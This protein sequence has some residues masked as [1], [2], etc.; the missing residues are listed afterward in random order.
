MATRRRSSKVIW[1]RSGWSSGSICW[2]LLVSGRFP[3]SKAIIPD[4][5]E[6]FLTPSA[7]RDTHIFGGLGLN[8][9]RL[10]ANHNLF[11][12]WA[13]DNEQRKLLWA[14]LNSTVTVLSKHQFGRAAGVEGNLKTEVVDANMMLVPDIRTASPHV[15]ARAIAACERI[16][17]R[18]AHRYLYDEF[19]LD[20][21]QALDDATL[22]ILGINDPAER[23]ALRD[24]I[25]CDL[26]AFQKATRE[27][28]IIAQRDRRNSSRSTVS[29]PQNM[30][31]ELWAEHQESLGLLE[32]PK[33]FVVAQNDGEW[34]DLP[35]GP[36]EV[37]T[38]LFDQGGLLKA[39][40]VRIGGRDG[41]VIEVGTMS[42]GQFLEVLS[43]CQRS[44]RI[45]LPDPASC[46]EAVSTFQRYRDDLRKRLSDLAKQRTSDERRQTSVVDALL[47]KALQ[48]RQ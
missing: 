24:H 21:R 41:I 5:Q 29:T 43:L 28:E 12:L 25:Y 47:R 35:S 10:P 45:R 11:E 34:L 48:W 1:M 39:G 7:H 13:L 20:D 37:G 8:P 44:G 40:T 36:V 38:A 4:G 17:K 14:V 31:D 18:D 2:V 42:R 32:F 26:T 27:R 22:E 9:D 6:H 19:V 30:A 3:V 33:E 15:A 46:A 16:A 23:T